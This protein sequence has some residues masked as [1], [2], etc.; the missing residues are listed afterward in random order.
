MIELRGLD[1]MEAECV[2]DLWVRGVRYHVRVLFYHQHWTFPKSQHRSLSLHRCAKA[3]ISCSY[4][5]FLPRKELPQLVTSLLVG[6]LNS[7]LYIVILL[8][9]NLKLCNPVFFVRV[10][11]M[12]HPLCTCTLRV[13]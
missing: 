3:A 8:Y 9:N 1:F 11:A 4:H 10:L 7:V 5:I 2:I 6:I 12:P 13:L